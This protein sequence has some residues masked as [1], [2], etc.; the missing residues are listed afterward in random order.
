MEAMRGKK[1]KCEADGEINSRINHGRKINNKKAPNSLSK[2]A[3]KYWKNV[4]KAFKRR[5]KLLK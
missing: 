1:W 4:T 2:L 3:K 5:N